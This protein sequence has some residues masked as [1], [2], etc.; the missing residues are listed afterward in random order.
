MSL[1][2]V[3]LTRGQPDWSSNTLV[4]K[5]SWP[6][7]YFWPEVNLSAI[8][9]H[10]ATRCLSQGVHLTR[11]QSD[12]SS[13]MLGHK[14]SLP[15]GGHLTTGQPDPKIWQK[16]QPNPRPYLTGGYVWPEV[17]L[18]EVRTHLATRCHHWGSI[19]PKVSQ[20]Q[21]SIQKCQPDLKHHLW[22]VN[23]TKCKKDIWKFEHA[24][25]FRSC[26]TEVFSTKDQ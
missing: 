10:L 19:W 1:L 7:G 2:G 16:C 9:T 11:G 22:G 24:L 15:G 20:T 23:L 25:H 21:R 13:Y 6:G 3:H 18:T 26:F 12:C 14:M 5:M 4:H 8:V 17:N